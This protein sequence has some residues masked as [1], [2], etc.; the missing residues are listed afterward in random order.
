MGSAKVILAIMALS[1][2]GHTKLI[3]AKLAGLDPRD[4]TCNLQAFEPKSWAESGAQKYLDDW[5]EKHDLCKWID[6]L[7]VYI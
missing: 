6:P 5:F 2:V 7:A 4:P 3:F 1:T